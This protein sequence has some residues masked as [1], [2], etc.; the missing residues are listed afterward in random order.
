MSSRLA[1]PIAIRREVLLEARHRCAVCCEPT[2]LE[3][4]HIRP[5]NES[6][7]H[8][9]ENLVALCANCHTR[10]DNEHWGAEYLRRY[11]SNPCALAANAPP[12]V[13]AEQQAIIDFVIASDPESMTEIQRLRFISIVAAYAG[14]R[15]VR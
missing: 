9:V 11:K 7:D 10:A 14:A 1:I 15:I 4:A 8:S 5:W 12:I 3:R 6:K 2:P 13:T